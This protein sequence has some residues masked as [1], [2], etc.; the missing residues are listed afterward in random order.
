MKHQKTKWSD[1]TDVQVGEHSP[2]LSEATAWLWADS[3]DTRDDESCR[4]DAEL[5]G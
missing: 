1:E 4:N 2:G 5:I 3:R